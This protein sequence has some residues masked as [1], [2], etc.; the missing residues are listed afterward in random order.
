MSL[1]GKEV[2]L[3][4]GHRLIVFD[5]II[6]HSAKNNRSMIFYKLGHKG[7]KEPLDAKFN[8]DSFCYNGGRSQ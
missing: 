8:A 1:I 7:M 4:N 2:E 3:K 6:E 5:I